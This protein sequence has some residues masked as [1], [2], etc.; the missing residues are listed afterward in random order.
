MT[1]KLTGR[2]DEGWLG[3]DRSTSERQNG[4]S[5][6]VM[7]VLIGPTCKLSF[8]VIARSLDEAK[9]IIN[10]FLQWTIE[11]D[12]SPEEP[13]TSIEA[14]WLETVPASHRALSAEMR[15]WLERYVASQGEEKV[16]GAIITAANRIGFTTFDSPTALQRYVGGIL[17]NNAR[18]KVGESVHV[19]GKAT[20]T[21]VWKEKRE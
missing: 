4:G 17:R 18:P 1:Q 5:E 6:Y 10:S 20:S 7:D 12:A 2:I 15:T 19:A 13:P 21:P 11:W 14:F 16:R 8:Q 3:A 9:S